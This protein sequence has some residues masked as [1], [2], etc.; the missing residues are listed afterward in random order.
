VFREPFPIIYVGDVE[1][2][3]RFYERGFGF[4]T[5]YRWPP[6]GR[7]AFAFLRLEPLGIGL[8][9]RSEGMRH[10]KPGRDFEL[11]LYT[12]DVDAAAERLRDLGATELRPPEDQPWG[13]RLAY[14][15]DPDGNPL[16]VTA[17][18]GADQD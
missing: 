17:K 12:D 11:C 5:V 9:A 2:S 13:E 16:H 10:G 1:D 4:E 3:V 8:A 15:E 6:E 18:L 14:F 7:L